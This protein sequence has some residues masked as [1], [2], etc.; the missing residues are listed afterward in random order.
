MKAEQGGNVAVL[1]T[2]VLAA[3]QFHSLGCVKPLTPSYSPQRCWVPIQVT[4]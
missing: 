4:C 2:A 3:P 1:I